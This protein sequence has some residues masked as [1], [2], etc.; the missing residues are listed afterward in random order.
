M[1][2]GSLH[3]GVFLSY[4]GS[5]S[6]LSLCPCAPHTDTAE[7][8]TGRALA[9]RVELCAHFRIPHLEHNQAVAKSAV[10]PIKRKRPAVGSSCPEET[11]ADRRHSAGAV[12]PLSQDTAVDPRLLS[13]AHEFKGHF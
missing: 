8:E 4:S 2:Y 3:F 5:S 7:R 6:R 9:P 13:C 12:C 11:A 1:G 10:W